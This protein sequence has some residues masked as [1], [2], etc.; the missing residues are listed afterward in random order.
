MKPNPHYPIQYHPKLKLALVARGYIL[1]VSVLMMGVILLLGTAASFLSLTNVTIANNVETNLETRYR[2]EAGIDA[3]IAYLETNASSFLNNTEIDRLIAEANTLT[4]FGNPSSC[5]YDSTTGIPCIALNRWT[6]ETVVISAIAGDPHTNAEYV[7]EASIRLTPNTDSTPAIGL[8]AEDVITIGAVDLTGGTASPLDDLISH[9]N[10]GYSID[11]RATLPIVNGT[12]GITASP[13]STVC[14]GGGVA[15]CPPE[16]NPLESVDIDAISE[17]KTVALGSEITEIATTREPSD[18]D[19]DD[20]DDDLAGSMSIDSISNSPSTSLSDGSYVTA[21]QINT[22]SDPKEV[23]GLLQTDSDSFT[24]VPSGE[25]IVFPEGTSL[26][27]AKLILQNGNIRLP[28]NGQFNNVVMIAEGGGIIFEGSNTL[29]TDSAAIASDGIDVLQ[30]VTFSGI[31]LLASD[32]PLSGIRFEHDGIVSN[33]DLSVISNGNIEVNGNISNFKAGLQSGGN[34]QLNG[35]MNF[36]GFAHAEGSI[37]ISEGTGRAE[38]IASLTPTE[39][40]YTFG[41]I[42]SR[43]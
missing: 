31:N 39:P 41:F 11:S 32:N 38:P 10:N 42:L 15:P 12:V 28:A 34:I 23:S 5:P 4:V 24:V 1:V 20:D 35:T 13:G 9:G 26:N 2:A 36:R 30:A 16:T 17:L 7:A 37:S 33:D 43:S 27:D 14:A 29:F 8:L 21:S 18:S 40:E 19:D 22:A 6:P 3:A 25:D